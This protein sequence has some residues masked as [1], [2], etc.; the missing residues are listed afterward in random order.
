MFD[1]A[2]LVTPLVSAAIGALLAWGLAQALF[3]RRERTLRES[4]VRLEAELGAA[5]DRAA[6]LDKA[7]AQLRE[8][9]QTLSSEALRQNN[10]SFL[11]LAKTTLAEQQR[12]ATTELEKKRVAIDGIVDPIRE[13]LAKV[14]ARIADVEKQRI[15]QSAALVEQLRGMAEGTRAL[16]METRSLSSALHTPAVRGRW[17]ELQLRRVVEL[18]GMLDHCDFYEQKSVSTETGRVRPDLIVR[19]PGG[20]NVVV[21]AKTPLEAFLQATETDDDAKR[22]DYLRDH[23]AQVRRHMQEL[24]A[25]SYWSQLESSPEFVV[26]FLPGEAFFSAAL[27]QDPSL[28]EYG[29]RERVIPASPTTLIAL[30]RAV[31]YGWRQEQVAEN[32]RAISELG[33][34]L[35]ERVGV[36]ARH[37]DELKR[38][39]DRAVH[40]YNQAVGS[41]ESRVLV[42]ARRFKELGVG[43][44][45]P[46]ERRDGLEVST[47]S[48]SPASDVDLAQPGAEGDEAP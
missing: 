43:S 16:Q 20:K 23:A 14:D 41:L 7:D 17:G 40:A 31:A 1:A 12:G 47:R 26:M 3:G 46:L 30:L 11:E 29:V 19:L 36:L 15:A 25:R 37:F 9:F 33:R 13:T 44:E 4:A 32:A 18:A 5:G 45:D 6:L 24:G 2:D 27:Q 48:A 22:S 38:G 35:H 21:D 28:I 8:A 34:D 42:S 39:L 10:Q